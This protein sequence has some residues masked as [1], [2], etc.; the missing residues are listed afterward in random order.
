MER[1]KRLERIRWEYASVLPN[2]LKQK[3]LCASEVSHFKKY[4]A[5]LN[6]YMK[7]VKID[8]TADLNPPKSL[9]IEVRCTVDF[10]EIQT[11]NGIVNLTKNSQ[12]FLRRSDVESLVKQGILQHVS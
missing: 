9:Y 4:S 2:H 7:S 6:S 10:G 1:M 12:H 5:N 8:L 3:I 11:E